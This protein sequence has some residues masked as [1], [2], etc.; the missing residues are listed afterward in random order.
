MFVH[1]WLVLG[2]FE[3]LLLSFC[4]MGSFVQSRR[5][6][7]EFGAARQSK[8]TFIPHVGIEFAKCSDFSIR[9]VLSLRKWHN[10]RQYFS[11]FTFC[12]TAC[13]SLGFS[14]FQIISCNSFSYFNFYKTPRGPSWSV[15]VLKLCKDKCILNTYISFHLTIRFNKC[16]VFDLSKS[17]VKW[18]IYIAPF[19]CNM[20]KGALQ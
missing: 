5:R 2:L 11:T 20:L 16:I 10:F 13:M 19:S 8:N 9:V 3:L 18:C 7:W 12:V 14:D 17:K 6:Q 1:G 4:P 15:I